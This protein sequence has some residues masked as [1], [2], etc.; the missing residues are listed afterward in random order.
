LALKR[1]KLRVSKGGHNIEPKT[2]RRRFKR[3]ISNFFRIYCDLV[4]NWVLLDNSTQPLII[5]ESNKKTLKINK[6]DVWQ[7]LKKEQ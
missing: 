2:I 7:K 3:G 4:D 6:E 1:V 5:A